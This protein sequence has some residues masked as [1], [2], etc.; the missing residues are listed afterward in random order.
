MGGG[1][2]IVSPRNVETVAKALACAYSI[3]IMTP[4]AQQSTG[5]PYLC[6]ATTSGAESKQDSFHFHCVVTADVN[7]NFSFFVTFSSDL[8][9]YSGV[10]QG[11]LM[12]PFSSLANWKSLM[13]ILECFKRL[14][15]T[16]FSN[17]TRRQTLLFCLF[18]LVERML[19]FH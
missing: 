11:S 17:C 4:I 18:F 14:K 9:R 7:Q 5:R 8:P 16:K 10:P 3:Y 12:S 1:K 6:L 19:Y 2:K 13:T 15:Y